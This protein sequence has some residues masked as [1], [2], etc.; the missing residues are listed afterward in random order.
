[1]LISDEKCE[2][3]VTFDLDP[4]RAE[5]PTAATRTK[6]AKKIIFVR[7]F[8]QQKLLINCDHGLLIKASKCVPTKI[9]VTHNS[10]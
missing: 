9:W 2:N 7:Q 6:P 5:T 8:T 10:L 1:M 4:G 3:F